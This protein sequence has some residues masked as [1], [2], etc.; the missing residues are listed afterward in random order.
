MH[1]S[2]QLEMRQ[3]KY[4]MQYTLVLLHYFTAGSL[5]TRGGGQNQ[6]FQITRAG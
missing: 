1:S 4:L 6:V 2:G 3:A 5:T